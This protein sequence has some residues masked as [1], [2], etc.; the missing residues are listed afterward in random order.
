MNEDIKR[1]ETTPAK[2]SKKRLFLAGL[3]FATTVTAFGV[4][5]K[6]INYVDGVKLD[7]ARYDLLHQPNLVEDIKD[8]KT[9]PELR[10]VSLAGISVQQGEV[11]D[12]LIRRVADNDKVQELNG[13]VL[14]QT[15]GQ[16]GVAVVPVEMLDPAKS[17]IVA[18]E[19]GG[20]LPT[21]VE[22]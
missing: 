4:G 19:H 16:P 7:N 14:D 18:N 12:T 9:P 15:E 10:G 1:I 13:Y 3:A 21:V 5:N 11:A 2:L 20:P 8:G 6:A 17:E 22:R